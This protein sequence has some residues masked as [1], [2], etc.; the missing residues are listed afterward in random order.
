MAV[1][2]VLG[3]RFTGAAPAGTSSL[4]F[5]IFAARPE[6]DVTDVLG[7]LSVDCYST[8]L[9]LLDR[10]IWVPTPHLIPK[11]PGWQQTKREGGDNRVGLCQSGYYNPNSFRILSEWVTA[12]A[13][14][15]ASRI[16]KTELSATQTTGHLGFGD[17][18]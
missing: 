2:T 7:A 10:S 15:V 12:K 1:E 16:R 6:Q 17:F 3:Y 5:R 11:L 8:D 4:Q 14:L 18:A 13:A 9:S